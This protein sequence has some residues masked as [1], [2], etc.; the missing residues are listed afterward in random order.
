MEAQDDRLLSRHTTR[1][2]LTTGARGLPRL[3]AISERKGRQ[4]TRGHEKEP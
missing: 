1:A 2:Y 3:G 4:K